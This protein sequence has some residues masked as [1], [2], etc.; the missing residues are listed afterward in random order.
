LEAI[1]F[2]NA[3]F[4][5]GYEPLM[6]TTRAGKVYNGVLRRDGPDEVVLATGATEEA[7][8]PRQEI[9]EMVPG[10]VSV[11]PSGLD[12]QLTP[13]ELADLVA[14]LRACK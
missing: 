14:F 2:P 12:Q 1:V 10:L 3:S 13:R 9:D 7:R 11:M 8:I 4:V 5:R 6:V